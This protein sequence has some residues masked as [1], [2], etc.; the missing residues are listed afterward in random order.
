MT[1][2]AA[3]TPVSVSYMGSRT[4]KKLAAECLIVP[5]QIPEDMVG[6]YQPGVLKTVSY[7]NKY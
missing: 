7:D 4:L 2:A 6:N 1:L 5:A 3:G